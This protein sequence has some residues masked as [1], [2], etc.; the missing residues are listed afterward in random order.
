MNQP[1][2]ASLPPVETAPSCPASHRVAVRASKFIIKLLL[3]AI[4]LSL[5]YIT[6]TQRS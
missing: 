1:E 6:L 3:T 4:A 5:I 2:N